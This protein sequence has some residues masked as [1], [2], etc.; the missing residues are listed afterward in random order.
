MKLDLY[1]L[2]AVWVV[3]FVGALIVAAVGPSRPQLAHRVAIFSALLTTLVGL[4]LLLAGSAGD[5]FAKT[6]FPAVSLGAGFRYHVGVDGLSAL[7]VPLTAIIG[8][9]VLVAAPRQLLPPRLA[10]EALFSVGAILGVLISLDAFWLTLFWTLSLWP[11]WRFAQRE[12]DAIGRTAASLVFFASSLPLWV[13]LVV[14]YFS[15]H[16]AIAPERAAA[17]FDLITLSQTAVLT[18]GRPGLLLGGL[19][20][21]AALVRMG[22]FPLH[23]W[24]PALGQRTRGPLSI[25][26]FATPLGVFLVARVVLPIFPSLAAR[27]LPSLLWLGVLT[28][29]VGS[30]GALGQ[31]DLRRLLSSFWICQQGF[32]LAGLATLTQEGVSGALLHAAGTVIART[33]LLLISMSLLARVGHTDMRKLGALVT[34]APVMATA[35]LLL[36][37]AAIGLPGSLCFV[38]EDLIAQGLLRTHGIA[39]ALL[40]LTSALNGITLFRAYQQIFLGDR[41]P[42]VPR[43]QVD[44][45]LDSLPKERWISLL[46][47]LLLVAGGLFA[48]PLLAIRQS[49]VD[50]LHDQPSLPT[51]H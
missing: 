16:T 51:G 4:W 11:L 48:K 38:S 1:T 6:D 26:A 27:C 3:P 19:L 35:F 2:T 10:A 29:L 47:V 24:I 12:L 7:L 31:H 44:S 25:A 39:A 42:G 36:A 13:A 5:A 37:A 20:L 23:L 50:A 40:L 41:G 9:S 45:F 14:L 18:Q 49:V 34:K 15:A 32:L 28:A 22:C 30:V 21:L 46:L 43:A 8:L 17:P 33:G